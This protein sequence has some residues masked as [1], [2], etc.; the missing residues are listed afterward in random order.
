[1]K[2]FY[3]LFLFIASDAFALTAEDINT[4][5]DLNLI[6][7]SSRG[8]SYKDAIESHALEYW[9][10]TEDFYNLFDDG[11]NHDAEETCKPN[12]KYY[13]LDEVR[14]VY[15]EEMPRLSVSFA[16]IKLTEGG[17]TQVYIAYPQATYELSYKFYKSESDYDDNMLSNVTEFCTVAYGTGFYYENTKDE[18]VNFI[19]TSGY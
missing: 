8:P 12:V 2:F 14:V 1:M 17:R 11:M 4:N 5:S 6:V 15:N 19:G 3:A 18:S 10:E 9:E 16:S 7:S 13:R